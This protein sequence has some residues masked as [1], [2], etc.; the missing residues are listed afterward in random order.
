MKLPVLVIAGLLLTGCGEM[1]D[2]TPTP[3]P[4]VGVHWLNAHGIEV[5]KDACV[6]DN[7]FTGS[8]VAC[9]VR[10]A[11]SWQVY[12]MDCETNGSCI[13]VAIQPADT[14]NP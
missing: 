6:P 1:S 13:I 4:S 2:S 14:L 8:D 10:K 3:D 5:S 11:D 9:S 12:R 7:G